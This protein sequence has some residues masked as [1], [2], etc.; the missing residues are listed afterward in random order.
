[1]TEKEKHIFNW[2]HEVSKVRQE[3]S[4]FAICPF[5]SKAKYRIVEC[6]ASAIEPIEGMDV[7]I[8]IIEDKFNLNEVQEWVDICNSKYN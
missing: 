6:S 3:L 1:M 2:I 8:Y 5:A 7:V 4:G